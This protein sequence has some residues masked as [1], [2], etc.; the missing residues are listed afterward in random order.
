MKQFFL[1][2]FLV[3]F[4]GVMMAQK[5]EERLRTAGYHN[6]FYSSLQVNNRG[7]GFGFRRGYHKT[8]KQKRLFEFDF[9][10]L[11][12]PREVN[13]LQSSGGSGFVFAKLNRAYTTRFGYGRHNVLAYKPLGDGVEIKTIATLGLTATFLMPVY[14][15]MSN[16]DGDQVFPSTE[17]FDPEVHDIFNIVENGPYFEGL[18]ETTIQP[19]IFGKFGLNFEYSPERSTIRSLE[20]GVV[21]DGYYENVEILALTDNYPI[22]VSFY[23]SLQYGS[24]WYR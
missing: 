4:S 23:L 14:Y 11:K 21:V 13:L 7:W 20:V 19:G 10:T 16:F 6:I 22:F 5:P 12:H 15:T 18:F 17:K 24:K 1:I 2:S 8:A 3:F 9:N